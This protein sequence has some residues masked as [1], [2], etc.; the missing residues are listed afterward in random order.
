MTTFNL[1]NAKLRPG[2]QFRDVVAGDHAPRELGGPRDVA[3][4]EPPQAVLTL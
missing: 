3:R 2:E 1:R 4:A